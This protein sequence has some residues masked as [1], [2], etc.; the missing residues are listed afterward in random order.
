MTIDQLNDLFIEQ[1]Y[2]MIKDFVKKVFNDNYISFYDFLEKKIDVS[3]DYVT[4]FFMEEIPQAYLK[5]LYNKNPQST[6]DYV[7]DEFLTDVKKEVIK[8]AAPKKPVKKATAK[9]TVAKK[10]K[11]RTR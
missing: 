7:V 2:S 9:K 10:T 6:I 8:P 4:E 1:E 11:G 3:M 5:I